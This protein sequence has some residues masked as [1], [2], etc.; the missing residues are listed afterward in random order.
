MRRVRVLCVLALGASLLSGCTL[1][2]TSNSPVVIK[3][4]LVG[5]ELFSKTIPGTVNGRVRFRTQPVYIVDATGHLTPFSRIV[6]SPP[7]LDSILHELVIGPTTIESFAG[8]TSSLPKSLVILQANI[9]N[10]IGYVDLARPLSTLAHA[11]EVLALG[12]LVFTANAVGATDGLEIL[13]AGVAQPLL[14]PNGRKA[15]LVTIG[16]YASLLNP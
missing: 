1:V 7:T 12:Q 13:V 4:S 8:Y 10:H 11:Q 9:K 14:L 3:R 2:P 15:L 5:Y 16:D 6:P